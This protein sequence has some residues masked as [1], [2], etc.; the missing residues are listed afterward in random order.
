MSLD[1]LSLGTWWKSRDWVHFEISSKKK[2]RVILTGF[3]V[4]SPWKSMPKMNFR[5]C[6][7]VAYKNE[8][9]IMQIMEKLSFLVGGSLSNSRG[10]NFFFFF[11]RRMLMENWYDIDR[12]DVAW[13]RMGYYYRGYRRARKKRVSHARGN[14]VCNERT[15]KPFTLSLSK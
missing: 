6:H 9:N 12:C 10:C 3:W 8:Q 1:Y 14:R 4:K 7:V 13:P 15:R 5:Y 2:F 11:F